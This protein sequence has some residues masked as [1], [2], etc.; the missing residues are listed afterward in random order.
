MPPATGSCEKCA[1]PFL[2]VNRVRKYCIGCQ[3]IR[4]V[5]FAPSRS[6]NCTECR[7]EFWPIKANYVQCNDCREGLGNADKYEPCG[8]CGRNYRPAP[9]LD[10]TCMSCV[11][12]TRDIRA[13]YVRQLK[14]NRTQ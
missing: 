8:R 14:A 6:R 2:Q 13:Q 10:G 5:D 3:I 4:D 1:R 12:R 11:M 9:E 7:Q